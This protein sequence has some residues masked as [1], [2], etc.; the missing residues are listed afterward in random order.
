MPNNLVIVESPAKSKTISGYLGEDYDVLATIGH[1]RDLPGRQGSI[2]PDNN[3]NMI[4]EIGERSREQV[5]K[6]ITAFKTADAL[7][8]ATDPDREGEAIAWHVTELLNDEGLINEKPI[9]RIVF[10]E[11]TKNAVREAMKNPRKLNKELV[12]AYL[13]RRAIDYL[14]GFNLSPLLWKTIGGG[15]K[16]A[17]RVQSPALRLIVERELKIDA[18]EA[19]EYWSIEADVRQ[20]EQTFKSRL[21]KYFGEK[22]EKFSFKNEE[23]AREAEKN[24]L[25]DA[26]NNLTAVNIEKKQRRRNPAAPFRTSTL[27]QE[28]SRKL[29]FSARFTMNVAQGLYMGI[30]LPNEGNIGL[31]TYMR[32]DSADLSSVAIDEIREMIRNRFGNENVPDKPQKYQSKAAN[33]QEAHEAIRPT[34]IT[35]TP[36]SM[37]TILDENQLKLYTL[38]W[39]RTM[40]SQ[41][42]AA[43]FDTVKIDLSTEPDNSKAH[44]FRANGQILVRP[45]FMAVYQESKDDR[46]VDDSDNLLPEINKGNIITIDILRTEQH[47]T[48]P[49]PRFTEASLVKTLEEYGIGRPSTYATIIAKLQEKYADMDGRRFQP[50]DTGKLVNKYLT[51]RFSQYIDYEFTSKLENQ[52][53]A[54]SR[55]EKQ[56]KPLVKEF[57][58]PFIDLINQNQNVT[59]SEALGS[60]DLGIDPESNKPVSVRMGH[61]GPYVMIG[62][63]QDEETPKFAGLR[64]EQSVENLTLEEALALFSLPRILGKTPEG[65][66]ILAKAGPFGAYINYGNKKNASIPRDEDPY[67]IDI[68]RALELIKEK[69]IADANRIIHNFENA[70]IQVLNGRY[71]PYITNKKKNARIPK[72]QDP[73]S[74]TLEECE[75]LL[76]AAPER[77]RRGKKK[78]T[79]KKIASG[80]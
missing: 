21:V 31:I 4:F 3:F 8:L 12:D 49:P 36:E 45:G 57:W 77:K 61:R 7:Y 56:F 15:A 33:A 35:R 37:E 20:K 18:F 10:Y 46:V 11:I 34:S 23:I 63:N 64:P 9:Y 47:F 24:I 62:T 68:S 32:T 13:A 69:E 42:E 66:D 28:A 25:N 59:R 76:A 44:Q 40:A 43:V 50:T 72:D 6:I 52:L 67:T 29:G 51:E 26:K 79:S 75:K 27:Q 54:V 71:G 16:S 58:G 5:K 19:Q 80:K 55:G 41:M 48:E 17:G 53:D 60:R 2:D 78:K 70:G 22:V 39:Q 38:I 73:E 14:F 74:L 1:I 30:E 65:V